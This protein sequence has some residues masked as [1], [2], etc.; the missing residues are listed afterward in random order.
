MLHMPMSRI[1]CLFISSPCTMDQL[2]AATAHHPAFRFRPDWKTRPTAGFAANT[3]VVMMDDDVKGRCIVR[4]MAQIYEE[5]V[6]HATYPGSISECRVSLWDGGQWRPVSYIFRDSGIPTRRV[7]TRCGCVDLTDLYRVWEDTNADDRVPVLPKEGMEIQH[8]EKYPF[9]VPAYAGLC[10]LEEGFYYGAFFKHGS[11]GNKE[12]QGQ[13]APQRWC[14]IR[15]H[16]RAWIE[17]VQ[18]HAQT[19]MAP[20]SEWDMF[21]V[22]EIIKKGKTIYSL[23]PKPDHEAHMADM[24]KMFYRD[25]V[26]CIPDE[27]MTGSLGMQMAFTTSIMS[28]TPD[29]VSDVKEITVANAANACRLFHILTTLRYN[30]SVNMFPSSN[31]YHIRATYCA[32]DGT[33]ECTC[34][35]PRKPH[36]IKKNMV[37]DTATEPTLVYTP[38]YVDDGRKSD[39]MMIG[40]GKLMVPYL[41]SLF[42]T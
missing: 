11:A 39:G 42:G 22:E 3:P 15:H 1:F 21:Y 29:Q 13:A 33:A 16:D 27:V 4:T 26:K 38:Y 41:K 34:D 5:G 17:K 37:L 6:P 25:G 14:H 2:I 23:A 31:L 32:N 7:L 30:V 9:V 35:L 24:I 19:A 28:D 36:M 20:Y 18:V 40:V 8:A 12:R 10:D